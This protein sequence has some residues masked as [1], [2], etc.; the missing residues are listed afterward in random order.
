MGPI[1]SVTTFRQMLLHLPD[2]HA[3]IKE[4]TGYAHRDSECSLISAPSAKDTEHTRHYANDDLADN[5]GKK[6]EF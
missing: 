4:S 1:C 6:E 5:L 3:A 2:V